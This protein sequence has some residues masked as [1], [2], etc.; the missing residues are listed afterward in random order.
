MGYF[1]QVK[2][3][4][5]YKE[6]ERTQGVSTT[7][8]VGR[9][10]LLTR[11]HFRRGDQVGPLAIH[12]QTLFATL[13]SFKQIYQQESVVIPFQNSEYKILASNSLKYSHVYNSIQNYKNFKPC[14][15]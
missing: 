10:L 7:D 1:I 14:W 9:M 11:E 15:V 2:K 6:V 8:L 12:S 13:L 3:S 5:R 4:G